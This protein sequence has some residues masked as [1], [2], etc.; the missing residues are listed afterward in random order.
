MTDTSG[1]SS[2]STAVVTVEDNIAPTV[3]TQDIAVQLDANGDASISASD[4]DNGSSDNCAIDTSSLNVSNFDCNDIG[5]N[6]VTLTVTDTSGNSSSS[7]A[8]VTVED[9]IAPTVI[10]QDIAVQLDA[11]GD[12]NISVSD[13]DNGSSDN[14]AIDTSSLDV[15]TFDCSDIGTI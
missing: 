3:V 5:D 15:S 13:I 1:N 8:V 11:N 14:C 7:T 10:T 9:N 12:A 4:I 6:T 2:S